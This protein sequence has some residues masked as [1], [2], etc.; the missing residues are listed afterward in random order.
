MAS[1]GD[2]SMWEGAFGANG[3]LKFNG[4]ISEALAGLW[5]G[6][7][8]KSGLARTRGPLASSLR[9]A[10]GYRWGPGT[11]SRTSA[12]VAP[13]IRPWLDGTD[14]GCCRFGRLRRNRA[15]SVTSNTT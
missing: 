15:G 13:Q 14:C 5:R 12:Y 11:R 7:G 10:R 3:R 8:E 6:E 1:D 4:T 2:L 9:Q